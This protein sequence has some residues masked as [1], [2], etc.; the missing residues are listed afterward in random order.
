MCIEKSKK[1]ALLNIEYNPNLQPL[2]IPLPILPFLQLRIIPNVYL[3][4]EFNFNCVNEKYEIG[5]F[6]N[7]S[8]KA[9]VSMDFELG[10]Y[11]P[12]TYSPV[13]LSITV[14]LKGVLGNGKI[15]LK[16]EYNLNQNQLE[17]FLDYQLEAFTLYF[18]IQYKFT[19]D[20]VLKKYQ[21][22]FYIANKRLFG[23]YIEGHKNKTVKF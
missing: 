2:I 23:I 11:I 22:Q 13:E 21:F 7:L 9:N 6:L 4:S 5:A 18:Y 20:L 15:G 12:G 10:F 17:Y 8:V 1:L 14:G 19:I 3:K 16:F